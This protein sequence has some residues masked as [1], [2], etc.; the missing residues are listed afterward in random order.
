MTATDSALMDRT[1]FEAFALSLPGATLVRQW[2]DASVAKV[3]G[4]IFAILSG[5]GADA[6]PGLSFKCSELAFA[7]LPELG[8]V[9]P[10]PYLA[11]AQWVQVLP[12]SPLTPDDLRAYVREA[13]RLVASRL[14]HKRRAEL[15]LDALTSA[16]PHKS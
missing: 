14:T 4:R 5:W 3:G 11:R 12:G 7:M 15:G 9:R 8:N 13:H 2:G 6:G 10:A 16:A 1:G